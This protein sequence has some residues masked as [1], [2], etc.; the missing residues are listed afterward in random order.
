MS[1]AWLD[2]LSEAERKA[3]APED[4]SAREAGGRG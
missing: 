3:V 1:P 4:Q 2:V